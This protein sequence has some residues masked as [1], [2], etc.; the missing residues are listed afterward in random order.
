[1]TN[2]TKMEL[3]SRSVGYKITST[4]TILESE[5]RLSGTAVNHSEVTAVS[6]GGLLC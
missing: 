1:M 2:I 4:Y 6:D 3:E 5:G